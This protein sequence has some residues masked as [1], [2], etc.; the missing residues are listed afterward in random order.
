VSERPHW[1]TV[2]S[3]DHSIPNQSSHASDADCLTMVV[4]ELLLINLAEREKD[5]VLQ[6]SCEHIALGMVSSEYILDTL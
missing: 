3:V 4:S 1:P 2:T 5:L 6:S